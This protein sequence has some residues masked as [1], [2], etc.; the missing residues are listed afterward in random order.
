MRLGQVRVV[1]VSGGKDSTAMYLLAVERHGTDFQAVFAD[2]GHEHQW[3]YEAVERLSGVS[4]GPP[5]RTV[6]ADLSDKFPARRASI[7]TRW[8]EQGVPP[9]VIERALSV[10]HPTGNPFLDA[11]LL[12][13]GFPDARMRFCTTA[14]K[15]EPIRDQVYRPIWDAGETVESWQGVRKDESKARSLLREREPYRGRQQDGECEVYRPLLDWSLEDVWAMHRR[16]GV[17]RNPLYDA[18]VNRVGCA[19]CIMARKSEV[20]ILARVAPECIDRVREWEKIVSMSSKHRSSLSSFFPV[21]RAGSYHIDDVVKWSKTSRGGR[22]YDIFSEAEMFG[23]CIEAG[24][25]GD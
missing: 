11:S 8:A 19:P 2:T 7:K 5:I 24:V 25:C 12:R 4:G 22:Q 6:Q 20:R 14:L 3:T 9:D 16:H 23:P 21:D 10:M 15:I 17:R 1:N 18:G 13:S